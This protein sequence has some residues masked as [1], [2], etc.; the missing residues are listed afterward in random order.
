MGLEDTNS[1]QETSSTSEGGMDMEAIGAELSADLF[2]DSASA[3]GQSNDGDDGLKLD[4]EVGG[5]PVTGETPPVA[6][7]GTPTDAATAPAQSPAP[8]T[9][10]PEAVAKWATL[11]PE[12]QAEVLKR[13]QDMFQGLEGYKQDANLG[14]TFKSVMDPYLP[15]LQAHGID[16]IKQVQGLMQAHLTLAKGTAEQ[17][18]AMFQKLAQDYGVELTATEPAYIDP[19]VAALQQQLKTLQSDLQGRAA[20]EAEASRSQLQKEIDTF[21]SDPSHPYFDDVANDIA[22]MLRNGAANLQE[23][24]DKAI[25]ANPITRAKEQARV[26]AEAA[27]KAKADADAKA[28][29]AKKAA[30]ANVR[31]SA[32]AASG[33]A[34]LGSIDDTLAATM[35][36]IKARV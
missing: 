32:K 12:V 6:A 25:W 28:A 33:T 1:T 3:E 23:A 7:P 34:P 17:K 29:A 15:T 31:S 35:A 14:K 9:W 27:A 36:N 18:Q 20:R 26:T 4:G 10:R 30:S 19:A 22:L 24:Y 8:K 13:E 11:P 2:P 21:A 16:P 5:A